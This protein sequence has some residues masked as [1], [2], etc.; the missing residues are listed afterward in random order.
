MKKLYAIL[1]LVFIACLA[2]E[3]LRHAF[4]IVPVVPIL[5]FLGVVF[6][7]VL[8]YLAIHRRKP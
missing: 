8:G 6:M 5:L 7:L 3:T 4:L 2:Y 1:A